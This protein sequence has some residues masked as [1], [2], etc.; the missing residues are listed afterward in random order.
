MIRNCRLCGNP[1]NRP[2]DRIVADPDDSER[3]V[4]HL[5]LPAKPVKLV[6]NGAMMSLERAFEELVGGVQPEDVAVPCCYCGELCGGLY[7]DITC[8]VGGRRAHTQCRDESDQTEGICRDELGQARRGSVDGPLVRE[9][10]CASAGGPAAAGVPGL[11]SARARARAIEQEIT[12]AAEQER[13]ARARAADLQRQLADAQ[14]EAMVEEHQENARA[15]AGALWLLIEQ[16]RALVKGANVRPPQ[17][18]NHTAWEESYT[19][20]LFDGEEVTLTVK[21]DGNRRAAEDFKRKEASERDT[22]SGC[23][24]HPA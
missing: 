13:M 19:F 11:A 21:H 6:D 3:V 20:A 5:C 4:H 1:C 7:K 17:G 14:R 15:W 2:G 9:S 24:P 22:L 16:K 8:I 18:W 12:E 10:A 23:M